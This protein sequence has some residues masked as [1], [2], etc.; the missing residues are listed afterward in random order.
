MVAAGLNGIP[1]MRDSIKAADAALVSRI[2][3]CSRTRPARFLAL[4]K[5]SNPAGGLNR[6]VRRHN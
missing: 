5:V 6:G 2:G 3:L 1:A 4:R